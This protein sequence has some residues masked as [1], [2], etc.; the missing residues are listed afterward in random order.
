MTSC[1]LRR[2]PSRTAA[3]LSSAAAASSGLNLRTRAKRSS[4]VAP[5][6]GSA[7][8]PG[9]ADRSKTPVAIPAAKSVLMS[10]RD[11]DRHSAGDR[12]GLTLH[13]GRKIEGP[14]TAHLRLDFH[15]VHACITRARKLRRRRH[16]SHAVRAHVEAGLEYDG[17][18][19]G[20]AVRNMDKA[21]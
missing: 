21:D 20:L 9:S 6:M 7:L 19:H 16:V 2:G 13:F 8:N 15:L 5:G 1:A 10:L 12:L 3:S 18:R 4:T 17:S 11:R 14:I